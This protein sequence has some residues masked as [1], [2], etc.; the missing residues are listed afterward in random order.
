MEPPAP[1]VVGFPPPVVPVVVTD[2]VEPVVADAIEPVVTDVVE[3][4][5]DPVDPPLP[6]SVGE[7][8]PHPIMLRTAIPASIDF[9]R[10][11]DLLRRFE[12]QDTIQPLD[13]A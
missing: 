6:G 1:E 5:A 9:D 13:T 7:L 3:L 11:I 10:I 4:P 8:P 12:A 2:V